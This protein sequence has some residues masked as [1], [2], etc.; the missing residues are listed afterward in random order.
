MLVNFLLGTDT[1][2]LGNTKEDA[3][4]FA[5][6]AINNIE[7]GTYNSYYKEIKNNEKKFWQF[8]LVNLTK[9]NQLEK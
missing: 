9:E 4:R 2:L 7:N 3:D 1:S 8:F 5:K 6:T